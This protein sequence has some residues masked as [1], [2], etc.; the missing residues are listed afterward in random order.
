MCYLRP[1]I[2]I[3][4]SSAFRDNTKRRY[5][6]PLQPM[7][8]QQQP[9]SQ[10]ALLESVMSL[11]VQVKSQHTRPS[12]LLSSLRPE[13]I[14]MQDQ[15]LLHLATQYSLPCLEVLLTQTGSLHA[16]ITQQL[17]KKDYLGKTPLHL[18]AANTTAEATSSI[19][20][21]T[22]DIGNTDKKG[23]TPL[24]AASKLGQYQQLKVS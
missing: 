4:N 24:H 13:G 20:N 15:G 12:P 3:A 19:L 6:I 7:Q 11:C 5:S 21:F 1:T 17:D 18:A 14:F 23:N 2:A 8:Q 16:A 22:A 10:K 9:S